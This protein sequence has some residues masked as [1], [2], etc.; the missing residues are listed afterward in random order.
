MSRQKLFKAMAFTIATSAPAFAHA[1]ETTGFLSHIGGT[2][3]ASYGFSMMQNSGMNLR[4]RNMGTFSAEALPGFTNDNWLFGIDFDYKIQRQFSDLDSSGGTNLKGT[5]WMVGLGTKYDFC[6]KFS[7]QASFD[8][9]GRYMFDHNTGTAEG[10]HLDNPFSIRFKPQYS[11]FTKIPVSIDADLRY[12][13]WR[14]FHVS[15][16]DH[17]KATHDWTTGL[18]LSLHF[19]KRN[20]I[21][22]AVMAEEVKTSTSSKSTNAKPVTKTSIDTLQSQLS[23]SLDVKKTD[24]GLLVNISGTN[25]F[26]TKST[27]LTEIAKNNIAKAAVI[28][29]KDPNQKVRIEGYSDSMGKKEYNLLLSK[30][31]AESVKAVLVEYGIK[32][33]N[34]SADGFGPAKPI[35]DNKT[36]EGRAANRRV[37]MYIDSV[38]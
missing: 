27:S 4:A 22:K 10:D 35:G 37:E 33:E 38:N 5:S 13:T 25:S 1:E 32:P 8:F 26:E 31:R 20:L 15:G 12:T 9:I 23:R 19:G 16:V 28:I 7:L 34:I 2:V 21:E 24:S 18:G 30:R 14:D 36:V 6:P 29:G 17:N 3:G 11:P